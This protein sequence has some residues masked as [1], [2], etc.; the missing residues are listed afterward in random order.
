MA[1]NLTVSNISKVKKIELI[2]L[3]GRI[4]LSKNV[5][6]DNTI[7]FQTSKLPAGMYQLKTVKI[8]YCFQTIKVIKL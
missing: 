6:N 4:V 2:D 8:D 7:I 5:K 3:A 1:N